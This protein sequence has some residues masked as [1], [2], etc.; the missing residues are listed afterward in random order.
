VDAG[1]LPITT[2]NRFGDGL[3]LS[4]EK[5]GM[6]WKLRKDYEIRCDRNL[7]F[8]LFW[9]L[10]EK[11]RLAGSQIIHET[12]AGIIDEFG[13]DYYKRFVREVIEE[14]REIF[15]K[16]C[17]ERLFPGTYCSVSFY[18]TRR[19]PRSSSLRRMIC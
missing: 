14:G 5:V 7:R 3:Y 11:A 12:L 13:V 17:L 18:E 19:M 1:G 4:C 9:H 10:D 15:T 8:P 6:E 2:I 16:R